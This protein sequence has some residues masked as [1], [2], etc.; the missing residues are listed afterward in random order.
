MKKY[1]RMS[2]IVLNNL[3]LDTMGQHLRFTKRQLKRQQSANNQKSKKAKSKKDE[4]VPLNYTFA[5]FASKIIFASDFK[6]IARG[7]VNLLKVTDA[8]Y[9]GDNDNNNLKKIKVKGFS[10]HV[11]TLF[12]NLVT[13]NR[14]FCHWLVQSHNEAF[15]DKIMTALLLQLYYKGHSRFTS[16]KIILMTLLY[17]SKFRNFNIKLCRRL[18][19]EI[20]LE[21]GMISEISKLREYKEIFAPSSDLIG[22]VSSDGTKTKSN[23]IALNKKTDKTSKIPDHNKLVTALTSASKKRGASKETMQPTYHDFLVAILANLEDISWINY[24]IMKLLYNT[25]YFIKGLSSH[26]CQ[27]FFQDI[28]Q[29]DD[30]L[31][32]LV[33]ENLLQYQFD[34]NSDFVTI[35]LEKSDVIL[36]DDNLN[37]QETNPTIYQALTLLKPQVAKFKNQSGV[38]GTK[39][40][41]EQV[42][43]FLKSSTLVGLLPERKA[44]DL[45]DFDNESVE[46]NFWLW[47]VVR[48]K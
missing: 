24:Y 39:N 48:G 31:I 17:L 38:K 35:L 43:N 45:Y 19:P 28:F 44:V 36:N 20:L 13:V 8:P 2:L 10:D 37:L 47:K 41:D 15:F 11:L 7:F 12:W 27:L 4:E 5:E 18:R 9:D 25:S 29:R 33:V 16:S 42:G 32:Y 21:Y 14:S 26:S 40:I 1:I 22:G 23:S 34:T 6:F 30:V 46:S 3:V